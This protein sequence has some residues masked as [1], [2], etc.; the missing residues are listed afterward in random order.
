[1]VNPLSR[2]GTGR[3]WP[4]GFRHPKAG[5]EIKRKRQPGTAQNRRR[6]CIVTIS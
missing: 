4:G 6:G 5:Q 2:A 3:G 1:M